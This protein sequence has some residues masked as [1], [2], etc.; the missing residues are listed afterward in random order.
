MCSFH[1][2]TMCS[3][4]NCASVSIKEGENEFGGPISNLC[5]KKPQKILIRE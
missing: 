2:M 3:D 5:H 4:T 1:G